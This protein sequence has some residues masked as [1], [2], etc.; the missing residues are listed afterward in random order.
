[1]SRR[2]DWDRTKWENLP[3]QKFY[4]GAPLYDSSP[5]T[6][7]RDLADMDAVIRARKEKF[8]ARLRAARV[9]KKAR[10]KSSKTHAERLAKWK[11]A[12]QR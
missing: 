3:G 1:M 2:L 12:R 4:E 5:A 8:D 9:A 10:R 6:E 11:S 7:A